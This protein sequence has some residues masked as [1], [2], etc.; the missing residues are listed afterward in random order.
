MD[1]SYDDGDDAR[2]G[3]DDDEADNDHDEDVD[4]T[5][6]AQARGVFPTACTTSKSAR[7]NESPS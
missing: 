1:G 3:D 2:N 7:Y 6:R 5:M 4:M